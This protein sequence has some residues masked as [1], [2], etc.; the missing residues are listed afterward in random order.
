MTVVPI[1]S[2]KIL[3]IGGMFKDTT[4]SD[5][6]IL[7]DFEKMEFSLLEDLK[8]EKKT[9]F[10]N[11]YFLFFGDYAY[12]FDNEGDIHEFSVKDLSFKIVNH[13]KPMQI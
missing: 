5:E 13:H 11:K 9:C 7:F 12:Q 10:P 8:L 2:N 3:L 6:I 4:Y 1:S